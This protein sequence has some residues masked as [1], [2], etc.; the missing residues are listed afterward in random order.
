MYFTDWEPGDFCSYNN[1][2]VVYVVESVSRSKNTAKV[3]NV[4]LSRKADRKIV[5]EFNFENMTFV[6]NQDAALLLIVGM[7]EQIKDSLNE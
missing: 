1:G 3:R 5:K 7:L 2:G 6:K 4:C